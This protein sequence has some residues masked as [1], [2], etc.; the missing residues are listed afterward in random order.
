MIID[1]YDG[2]IFD[3]DGTVYRGEHIIPNANTTVNKVKELKKKIIFVSNKTTDSKESYFNFL[4]KH[5][6]NIEEGE[7]LT[8]LE[9]AKDYLRKNFLH[10]KF[11]AIGEQHFIDEISASNLIYSEDPNEI[12]IVLITLD[13]TFNY[14]KLEIAAKSIEQGAKFFAANIDN[15]CPVDDGEIWDAGSTISALEKRTRRKLEL[16]FGKPSSLMINTVLKKLLLDREKI[17]IVGDRL[18]TDI[19]MGNDFGI[20][21]ALVLTGVN[22]FS[23]NGNSIKPKYTIDSVYDLIK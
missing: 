23:D 17:L 11:F 16:N 18:E 5:D 1:N 12:E 13:R 19:K 4:K 2:F 10:K 6:F 15:T 21:S 3:L 7:I 9:I 22:N 20:D 8:A 14:N